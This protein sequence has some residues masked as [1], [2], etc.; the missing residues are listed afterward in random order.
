[1]IME[2]NQYGVCLH[3]S[4]VGDH[5]CV[6]ALDS[7]LEDGLI[8][9]QNLAKEIPSRKV[10]KKARVRIDKVHG[11]FVSANG[12]SFVLAAAY[13]H[14]VAFILAGKMETARRW[15]KRAI[16][17]Q[18]RIAN[19]NAHP[20]KDLLISLDHVQTNRGLIL[21]VAKRIPCHCLEQKKLA[22]KILPRAAYCNGCKNE[23]RLA[24]ML[25]C[26]GCKTQLYCSVDCQWGDWPTHKGACRAR[27]KEGR[28]ITKAYC[29]PATS[30][31]K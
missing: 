11:R 19:E 30:A 28:D 13:S 9:E 2:A 12:K 31:K 20:E 27:A 6:E 22:V 7:L 1:M 21:H 5:K 24:E 25:Q 10:E 17:F 4:R 23:K 14:S 16:F 29:V 3:G 15:C 8:I 26:S 18:L